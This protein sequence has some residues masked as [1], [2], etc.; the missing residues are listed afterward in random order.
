MSQYFNLTFFIN[1]VH[2]VSTSQRHVSYTVVDS[3]I[4]RNHKNCGGGF[5]RSRGRRPPSDSRG[6][7]PAF[8]GSPSEA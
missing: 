1:K 7:I 4:S 3:G 2:K 6:Q 8:W 5:Q